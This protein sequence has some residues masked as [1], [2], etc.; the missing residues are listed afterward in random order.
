VVV[1]D[2]SLSGSQANRSERI[3]Q[4]HTDEPGYQLRD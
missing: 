3:R 2:P 1:A 4:P